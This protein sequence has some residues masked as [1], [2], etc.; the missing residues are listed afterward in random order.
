M[1]IIIT[2]NDS[3][4]VEQVFESKEA[5]KTNAVQAPAKEHEP[6]KD[7]EASAA[8]EN[9]DNSDIEDDKSL[10][11]LKTDNED[12]ESDEHD[13]EEE[14]I[15][16]EEEEEVERQPKKNG[17]KKRIDKLLR[18]NSEYEARIAQLEAE[19]KAK[20]A[21]EPVKVEELK[22][23]D[24][25]DFEDHNDYIKAKVKYEIAEEKKNDYDNHQNKLIEDEAKQI[26]AKY[27]E[28]VEEA[29]QRY[30]SEKWQKLGK[31]DAPLSINTRS[32]IMQSEHGPDILFYLLNNLEENNKIHGMSDYN[33]TKAIIDIERKVSEALSK[34][35]KT[36]KQKVTNAPA[37]VKPISSK[38][39]G[40]VG[41][42]PNKM[43]FKEYKAWREKQK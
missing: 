18:K 17:V 21:P 24:I 13:D 31:I 14:D 27:Q 40:K 32:A 33:Q 4:Q 16:S 35:N 22:E 41:R 19:R 42:D 9:Q 15:E 34:G 43:D 38:V 12:D 20:P 2:T 5:V 6:E 8:E 37:P 30:G 23:P 26:I 3:E 28:R 36:P 11:Y 10:D 39:D 29:K 7:T 25:N 1:P